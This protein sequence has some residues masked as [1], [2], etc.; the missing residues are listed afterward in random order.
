MV[1]L[2]FFEIG[3][4]CKVTFVLKVTSPTRNHAIFERQANITQQGVIE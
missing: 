1:T 3:C 4:V 2:P